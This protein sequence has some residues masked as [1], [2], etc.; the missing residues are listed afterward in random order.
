[1]AEEFVELEENDGEESDVVC[2]CG[3][4]SAHWEP[5]SRY[6]VEVLICDECGEILDERDLDHWNATYRVC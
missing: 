3:S 4:E 1:M 5:R 2:E 6:Y